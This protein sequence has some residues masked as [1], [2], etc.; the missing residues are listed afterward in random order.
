MDMDTLIFEIR[1]RNPLTIIAVTDSLAGSIIS[2]EHAYAA[3]AADVLWDNL[4]G[5][6]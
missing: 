3:V 6:E 4:L 1:H 2:P 5:A